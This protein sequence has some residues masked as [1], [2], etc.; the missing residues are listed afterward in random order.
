VDH[1]QEL[2][3]RPEMQSTVED[4]KRWVDR[5]RFSL[6]AWAAFAMDLGNQPP[7]YLLSHGCV[8]GIVDIR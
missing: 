2:A 4:A 6:E 7:D 8:L 1:S 3:D 5:W